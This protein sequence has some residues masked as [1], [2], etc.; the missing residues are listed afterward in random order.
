MLRK[1]W[2]I[3]NLIVSCLILFC[4]GCGSEVTNSDDK[5]S[6]NTTELL[7]TAWAVKD[8]TGSWHGTAKVVNKA[9]S[10]M[11]SQHLV[12]EVGVEGEIKGTIGWLLL[13][14]GSEAKN[15]K[16]FGH[17]GLGEKVDEHTEAIV[18]LANFQE[19][20]LTLV[21]CEEPGTLH[22]TLRKDGT[23]ELSRSQPGEFYVV[24]HAIL[25]RDSN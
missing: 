1:K 23:L 8:L 7:S 18:G 19:G 10:F 24:T 2:F 20:T 4:S 13:P 21:E 17:N 11:V 15:G 22:G 9:G 14:Q 16:E 25:T 6:L 12:L 3:N 5:R